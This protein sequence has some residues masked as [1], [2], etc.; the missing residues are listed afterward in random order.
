MDLVDSLIY[1]QPQM[2]PSTL[3]QPYDYLVAIPGTNGDIRTQF[4]RSFNDLYFSIDNHDTIATIS[5]VITVF[6]NSSLLIDDIEDGSEFRRGRPAAHTKYGVALTLNCGNMMY[7][8]ALQT[9]QQNLPQFHPSDNKNEIALSILNILVEELLNLHHGQGLDIHWRDHLKTSTLPLIQEYME[10]IMNK[11]GGLFRLAVKLLG[12]FSTPPDERT[13]LAIANLFGIVFQ[14]RDD[15]MNLV[16]DKYSHMKGMKGEDLVEGKLSLPILHCLHSLTNDSPVTSL[17]YH[18][19]MKQR[20]QNPQLVQQA[21]E[22]MKV[23]TKSL[24]YAQDLLRLYGAKIKQLV[25]PDTNSFLVQIVDKLLN[26]I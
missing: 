2:V 21:V 19:D 11:T 4:I 1:S 20:Q 25:G 6:H 14:I 3:R 13:V 18:M 24:Q 17:L 9:A 16:D 22:Y 26:S 5:E 23:E 7:F 15:V 12:V 8:V 10:M